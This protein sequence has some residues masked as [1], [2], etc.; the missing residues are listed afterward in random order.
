MFSILGYAGVIKATQYWTQANIEYGLNSLIITVEMFLFCF[1]DWYAYS[2][3]EFVAVKGQPKRPVSIF[4]A[5]VDALNIF[6]LFVEV[7][8]NL[9]WFW[10]AVILRREHVRNPDDAR[11]DIHAPAEH[12]AELI[13]QETAAVYGESG[14]EDVEMKHAGQSSYERTWADDD[15][16]DED[17]AAGLASNPQY[18]AVSHNDRGGGSAYGYSEPYRQSLDPFSESVSEYDPRQENDARVSEYLRTTR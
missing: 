5:A 6:D 2:W 13:R 8:R 10:F 1:L 17:E 18:P 7:G 9:K 16:I 3:K 14:M 12:R 15:S 4:R 11:F